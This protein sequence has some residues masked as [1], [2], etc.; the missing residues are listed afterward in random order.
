MSTQTAYVPVGEIIADAALE[1]RDGDFGRLGRPFY[2]AAAFRGL[3]RM[4]FDTSFFR[5][6]WNE[7][8][9]EDLILPLP[10][11]IVGLEGAWLFNGEACDV[12]KSAVLFIKP[13]MHRLGGSGHIANNKWSN[14]DPLQYSSWS[15]QPPSNLFFA[16]FFDN[17]LH[18]S[19]SCRAYEKVHILYNAIPS[20]E[21]DDDFDIPEWAAEAITDFVIH[22]GA[23]RLEREDPQYLS[24]LIQRKEMELK[25]PG[26][27]WK[28]AQYYYK[29]MDRKGRY[30]LAART[31]RFGRY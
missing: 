9:P 24:R 2:V 30:D 13:N 29:R 27:S 12:S 10:S 15:E 6:T 17:S 28:E 5:K 7:V 1:L 18:L 19:D 31:F 3:R 25:G 8:V 16:G 26:G 21:C 11:D 20:D 23:L 4:C 14:E 22:R